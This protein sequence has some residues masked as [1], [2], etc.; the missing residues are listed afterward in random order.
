LKWL[1]M[2]LYILANLCSVKKDQFQICAHWPWDQSPEILVLSEWAPLIT[3]T[4]ALLQIILLIYSIPVFIIYQLTRF[5]IAKIIWT[6]YP[7]GTPD[8]IL[9]L[10]SL[11]CSICSLLCGLLYLFFFILIFLGL[12]MTLP[13]HSFYDFCLPLSYLHT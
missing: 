9:F 2:R 6:A 5:S 10:L 8:I 3:C 13:L 1:I 4:N 12:A 11:C 7:H